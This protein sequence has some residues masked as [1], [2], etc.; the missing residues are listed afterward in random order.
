MWDH[1]N[2]IQDIVRSLTRSLFFR[3][4][5]EYVPHRQLYWAPACGQVDAMHGARVPA[6]RRR[7]IPL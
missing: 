2:F 7:N 6:L 4:L 1:K 5:L 3:S